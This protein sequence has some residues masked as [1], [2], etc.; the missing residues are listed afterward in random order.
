MQGQMDEY[1]RGDRRCGGGAGGVSHT[2]KVKEMYQL[3]G[4]RC[5]RI[6]ALEQVSND[7]NSTSSISNTSCA[8]NLT[9]EEFEGLSM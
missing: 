8:L 1:N 9:R 2:S 6:G 5:L 3:E 7:P 4:L